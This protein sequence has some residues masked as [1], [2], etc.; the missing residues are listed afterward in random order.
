MRHFKQ[1]GF[2][3]IDVKVKKET[4]IPD[5]VL[6]EVLSDDDIAKLRAENVGVF[7]IT[8]VAKKS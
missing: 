7:S 3:D 6:R 5:E 4:P 1:T 2:Q 8:V